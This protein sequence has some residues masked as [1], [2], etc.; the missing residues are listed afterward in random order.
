MDDTVSIQDTD[1]AWESGRL[2]LEEKHAA[3]V[4]EKRGEEI[5]ALLGLRAISIRLPNSLIEDFKILAQLHGM[6]YQPLMREALARF[7]ESEKKRV[8]IQ[9]ANDQNQKV[10]M[11]RAAQIHEA[12]PE[13]KAA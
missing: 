4:S 6:G 11:E 9:Y 10:E 2:G 7:A 5:D 3:V 13:S 8:L 1:E 12:I